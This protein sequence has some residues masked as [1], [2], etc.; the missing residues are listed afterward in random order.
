M[1]T[2]FGK[3]VCVRVIFSWTSNNIKAVAEVSVFFCYLIQSY[4]FM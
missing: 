4:F 3:R 2:K 1:K